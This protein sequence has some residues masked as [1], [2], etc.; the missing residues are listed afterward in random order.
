MCQLAYAGPTPPAGPKSFTWA[1]GGGTVFYGNTD[2]IKFNVKGVDLLLSGHVAHTPER[3]TK[4]NKRGTQQFLGYSIMKKV[5]L[6]L[7]LR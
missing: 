1:G 7:Y 3:R 4:A 2:P 6:R 5:Y